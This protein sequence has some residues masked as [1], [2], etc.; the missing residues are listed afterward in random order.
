VLVEE[1]YEEERP[2]ARTSTY[3][4]I[5][6]VLLGILGLLLFLLAR[7]LGVGSG[8]E[9][10]V[11]NVVGDTQA[12]ATDKLR[13][14]GLKTSASTKPD[15]ANQPGAVL[16]QDPASGAR[17][18]KGSTVHLTVAGEAEQITV[19]NVVGKK[20]ADATDQ[21]EGLGFV[22][23]TRDRPDDNAPE[24]QVLDQ[25]PKANDKATKGSTVTIIVSSGPTQVI[26]PGLFN[27]TEAD[28]ASQL[29]QLGLGV[30]RTTQP[31][32]SVAVGHVIRTDP[33]QGSSVDKGSTVTLIVSS[34]PAPT[35]APPPTSPATTS[36]P[37]T[38]PATTTTRATTTTTLATLTTL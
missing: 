9:V 8:N 34:G 15:D 23:Q 30:D 37:T 29:R 31:D 13:D 10:V 3:V 28:A 7:T 35:T 20:V 22:V 33:A 6:A 26:V 18:R 19:P 1:E 11:P 2:P 21:L 25:S 38:S 27:L 14:A 24:G 17:V 5:L 36:P 4:V 16:D 32:A 12:I